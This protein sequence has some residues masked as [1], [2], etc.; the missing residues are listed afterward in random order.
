V[1]QSYAYSPFGETTPANGTVANPF[2]FTGRENEENGLGL[3]FYR[4]RYYAPQWGRFISE[5][6]IGLA[7]GVNPYTYVGNDPLDGIDPSGLFKL[8]QNPSGL[9]PD[10]QRDPGHGIPKDPDA[11]QRWLNKNGKEGLEWHRGK[12]GAR[13]CQDKDHWHRL[14][15]DPAGD[16]EKIPNDPL[17]DHL[18][19]GTEIPDAVPFAAHRPSSEPRGFYWSV[20]TPSP[21][22][23][24]S[25]AWGTVGA[26]ALW[27]LSRAVFAL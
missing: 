23:Q 5:D 22:T 11:I 4:N 12:P 20:P 6:P 16:W 18:L 3:Y 15:K 19:P 2:Q 8:P 1:V 27:I 14:R 13:G 7:G 17:G 24:Q 26:V 25:I 21:Q 10:W 9:G